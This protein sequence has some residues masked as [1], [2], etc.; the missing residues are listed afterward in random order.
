[1]DLFRKKSYI[2]ES[3]GTEQQIVALPKAATEGAVGTAGR[4]F[5]P[6]AKTTIPPLTGAGGATKAD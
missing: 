1:M 2:S 3:R 5:G 4:L 6:C